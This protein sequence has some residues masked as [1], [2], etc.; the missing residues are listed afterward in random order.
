MN[1]YT[2]WRRRNSIILDITKIPEIANDPEF[3]DLGAI[4][5]TL[6]DKEGVTDVL[7]LSDTSKNELAAWENKHNPRYGVEHYHT[8]NGRLVGSYNQQHFMDFNHF[9]PRNK[10]TKVTYDN[11]TNT[12]IF[13]EDPNTD[14]GNY[15]KQ[16]AKIE[17]NPDLL[18]FY[19][20][21]KEVTRVIR[22]NTPYELQQQ[23]PANTLPALRKVAGDLLLDRNVGGLKAI[24][25]A[26]R[27]MIDKVR[28]GFG[29]T[30]QNDVSNANID[31]TGKA[32]YTVNDDFLRA[33]SKA[34]STRRLIEE[35]RF[36]EAWNSNIT[37]SKSK[38]TSIGAFTERELNTFNTEALLLIAEY[39]HTNISLADIKAGRL[40][41]IRAKTGDRVKVGKLI[42]DYA[43][44]NLV[45]S[46]SFDLPKICKYFSDLTM[47]YAARQ[48]ALPIM[49]V[50]KKYYDNIQKPETNNTSNPI[51][52]TNDKVY[53]KNGLRTRAITQ[54]ASQFERTFLGNTGQKHIGELGKVQRSLSSTQLAKINNQIADIDTQIA[55]LDSDNKDYQSDL[56]KLQNRKY[57]LYSRKLIPT[58]GRK[59][60]TTEERLRVGELQEL[61]EK[62][63]NSDKGLQLQKAQENIGKTRTATAILDGLLGWINVLKLGYNLSSMTTNF[64]EGMVSNMTLAASNQYFNRDEIYYGYKVM[65]RAFIKN[66]TFGYVEPKLAKKARTLMDRFNVVVDSRNEL[67]KSSHK[68]YSNKLEW[69]K[70]SSGNQRVEYVN[71]GALMIATLRSTKIKGLAPNTES[72]VWDAYD[73]EGKLLPNYRTPENIANWEGLDGEQYTIYKNNLDNIIIKGHGNYSQMRGMMA[74]TGPGKIFLTFKTWLPEALAWRLGSEKPDILSGTEKS[75]GLYRSYTPTGAAIHGGIVGLAAFGPIGAVVGGAVGAVIGRFGNN[76][77]DTG[78]GVL[79]QTVDVTKA[80][81]LKALGMPIN[82]IVGKAIIKENDSF[83]KWIGSG[84]RGTFTQQDANNLRANV[85]D[86]ALQLS[87]ILMILVVKGLFWDD[88]DKPDSNSRIAHNILI[89]KLTQLSSQAGSYTNLPDIYNNTIGSIGLIQYLTDLGKETTAIEKY[90]EGTDV[91]STGVN[92]GQSRLARQTNK[93]LLPGLFKDPFSLGFETQAKTLYHDSPLQS[94]FTSEEKKD[95]K[96]NKGLR[97]RMR[98]E[99]KDR[100]D[101]KAIE[102]EKERSKYIESIINSELPTPAQL[103]KLGL[104]RDEYETLKDEQQ[105]Q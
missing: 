96:V 30:R 16:F 86:I 12:A 90:L 63:P 87:W 5:E 89:N 9:I 2:D 7:D 51:Y 43:L 92:A 6:L 58:L 10:V 4:R 44:N 57:R 104:T 79:R 94:L 80:L 15:N 81:A 62:N 29:V 37:K 71:Q 78:V 53:Q 83:D 85:A 74:K 33:N 11:S 45:Q 13:T 72:S 73:T 19:N 47:T 84:S 14:T 1:A 88:D 31:N 91:I 20:I 46:Q 102:D 49:E 60:Y 64:I 26:F 66:A 77:V 22:E 38:M 97:A 93:L 59:I 99:L 24:S 100:E 40:D 52:N 61:I 68:S 23:L 42:S 36:M 105:N 32:N 50:M 70:W 39:T 54:M 41:A 103:K 56:K 25:P 67:Q 8:A 27:T 28:T 82:T 17:A 3:D 34:I 55:K 18:E 98:T 95:A 76:N 35:T 65:R 75:K 21:A 48:E 101:I 69:A